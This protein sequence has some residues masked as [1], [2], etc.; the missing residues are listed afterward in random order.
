MATGSKRGEKSEK[1]ILEELR[2]HSG[3]GLI[4]RRFLKSELCPDVMSERTLDR[5]LNRLE[6]RKL[7]IRLETADR[8]MLFGIAKNVAEDAFLLNHSRKMGRQGITKKRP[9]PTRG[10]VVVSLRPSV[11]KITNEEMIESL[12]HFLDE[13]INY[14]TNKIQRERS[15]KAAE[16][17]L[18][19]LKRQVEESKEES[20]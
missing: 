10:E 1:L 11:L 5:A 3:G 12:E 9:A 17:Q 16:E 20:P 14:M 13:S 15:R 2:H 19:R 18:E 4:S 8:G 7:I 6:G